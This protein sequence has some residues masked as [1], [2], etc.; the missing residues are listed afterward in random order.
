VV[1]VLGPSNAAISAV[2]SRVPGASAVLGSDLLCDAAQCYTV[3]DG[4]F[5]YRNPGH[6]NRV[7]SELLANYIALPDLTLS[8][9]SRRP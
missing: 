1:E 3:M 5:L 8:A 7:G 6:L 4:V 2:A 9:A